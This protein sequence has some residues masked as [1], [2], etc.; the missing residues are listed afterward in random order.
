MSKIYFSIQRT[1]RIDR[2]HSNFWVDMYGELWVLAGDY[3]VDI[4]PQI[5]KLSPQ[6][7]SDN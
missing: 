4:V 2:R 1:R 3:L 7:K 5:I 6:K